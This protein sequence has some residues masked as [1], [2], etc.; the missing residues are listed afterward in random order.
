MEERIHDE[1]RG[2]EPSLVCVLL[3]SIVLHMSRKDRIRRKFCTQVV[4]LTLDNARAQS[5]KGLTN[6][7]KSLKKLSINNS[8]EARQLFLLVS[9]VLDRLRHPECSWAIVTGRIPGS[10]KP[11]GSMSSR[12]ARL[13][14]SLSPYAD[15]R[16]VRCSWRCPT[17]G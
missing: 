3:K 5:I 17:T 2:R 4:E 9:L 11:Q 8:M 10:P 12:A 15:Q 7:F 6:D 13:W 1:L 14:P 16:A